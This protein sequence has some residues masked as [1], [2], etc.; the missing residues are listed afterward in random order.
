[1]GYSIALRDDILNAAFR[2]AAFP[3][4]PG[5]YFI[6]LLTTNPTDETGAGLVE[7]GTSSWTNYA[8]AAI[9]TLLQ[10]PAAP[11]ATGNTGT[12]SAFTSGQTVNVAVTL[13][14]A[15]GETTPSS[16]TLVTIGAN[17]DNVVVTL[18]SF[19]AGCTGANVYV[20]TS[21]GSTTLYKTNSGAG[22]TSTTSGGTV[23]VTGFAPNTNSAV[24][25]SNTTSGYAAPQGG[26]TNPQ[27]ID[28]TNTVS[29]GTATVTGA[30]PVITGFALYDASSGG[31]FWG[32]AA[33]SSNQTINNN[34]PVSFAAAALVIQQ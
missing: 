17:G 19:P 31:T 34:D 25:G 22:A 26:T 11:S 23:T 16:D 15:N 32:W 9:Q 27:S 20:S 2:G 13:L 5:Q 21:T 28:N 6:A 12:G 10:V 24:P 4:M 18:P 8:R 7:C 30:A 33:L 29:F 14:N 3:A 1:M